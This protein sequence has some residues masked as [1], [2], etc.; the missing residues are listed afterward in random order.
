MARKKTKGNTAKEKNQKWHAGKIDTKQETSFGHQ[1]NFIQDFANTATLVELE[2]KELDLRDNSD[3]LVPE[4]NGRTHREM[5]G[6]MK[7]VSHFNLGI[8]LELMLKLLLW[9]NG[10]EKRQGHKLTPLYALLPPLI[11]QRLDSTFQDT[12]RR[13]R[14]G[15]ELIAF[16]NTSPPR[17]R[18]PRNRK[19]ETLKSYLEYFDEDV[20]LWLMRYSYESVEQREW[21]HYLSDLTLFIKLMDRV[22]EKL[23]QYIAPEDGAE[24]EGTGTGE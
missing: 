21:R 24:H 17:P 11:Q 3:A 12:K 2:I 10:K 18:P 9:V 8:A 19:L 13:L 14:G 15:C 7:S 5:W 6:S 23:G 1:F 22:L 20:R 16:I 4:M